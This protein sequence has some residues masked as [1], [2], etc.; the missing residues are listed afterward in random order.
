MNITQRCTASELMN[1]H[2][3][4][5]VDHILQDVPD[6]MRVLVLDICNMIQTLRPYKFIQKIS[7]V[8]HKTGFEIV[9]ALQSP[10]EIVSIQDLQTL[11]D[12]NATRIAFTCAKLVDGSMCVAVR[13]S[14][15]SHP[16]VL[17]DVQVTHIRKKQKWF[18]D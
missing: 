17:T 7:A 2:K 6:D 13:V 5:N 12:V 10:D 1:M 8:I 18:S 3:S 16:L 14:S 9:A 4:M 11:M 15:T